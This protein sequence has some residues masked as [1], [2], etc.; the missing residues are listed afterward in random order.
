MNLDAADLAIL[1]TDA[2]TA[3]ANQPLAAGIIATLMDHIRK[4]E[5]ELE[6]AE[7]RATDAETALAVAKEE[8]EE[9]AEETERHLKEAKAKAAEAVTYLQT[10]KSKLGLAIDTL[11]DIA[12][13]G[14]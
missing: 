3:F 6:E 2:A 10:L 5:G 1:E 14:E 12:A 9:A 11:E 8:E 7:T 13:L 4:L